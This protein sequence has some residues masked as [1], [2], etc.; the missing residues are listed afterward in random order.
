[1]AVSRGTIAG[2]SSMSPFKLEVTIE[3]ATMFNSFY[4][5]TKFINSRFFLFYI[6]FF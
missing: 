2:A 3:T 1:M 6:I 4:I 5:A